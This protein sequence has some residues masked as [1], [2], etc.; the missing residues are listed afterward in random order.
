MGSPGAVRGLAV[1]GGEMPEDAARGLQ[2]PRPHPERGLGSVR[3]LV[4]Q[5]CTPQVLIISGLNTSISGFFI[6]PRVA[7]QTHK[8]Q[9]WQSAASASSSAHTDPCHPFP[10]VLGVH[11]VAFLSPK[12][13]GGRGHPPGCPTVTLPSPTWFPTSAHPQLFSLVLPIPILPTP[14]I[15]NPPFVHHTTHKYL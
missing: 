5:S 8:P 6:R 3:V 15:L 13:H 1:V 7:P 4:A 14:R 11:K 12:P 10:S 9:R 2:T